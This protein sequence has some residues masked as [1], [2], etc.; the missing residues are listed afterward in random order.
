MTGNETPLRV[1]IATPNGLGG[2]GG[3]DRMNDMLIDVMSA[4]PEMNVVKR[5]V[6]RGNGNIVFAPFVLALALVRLWRAARQRKVD[7]LRLMSTPT[8]SKPR[9]ANVAAVGS[10]T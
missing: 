3:I 10:P 5:L 2:R 7:V 1:F 4:S 6:T 9:A 8:T